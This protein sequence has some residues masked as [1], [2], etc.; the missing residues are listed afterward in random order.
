V[1]RKTEAARRMFF[2]SIKVEGQEEL[3][4]P[5]TGELL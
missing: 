3:Q 1:N 5:S 4:T 2:I